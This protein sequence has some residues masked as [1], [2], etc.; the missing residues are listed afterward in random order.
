MTELK[1]NVCDIS[2]GNPYAKVE[3]I[4]YYISR[5]TCS[6]IGFCVKCCLFWMI[7]KIILGF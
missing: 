2:C 6:C 1:D 4:C 3:K 5:I 7:G